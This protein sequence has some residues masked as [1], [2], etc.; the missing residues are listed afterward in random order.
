MKPSLDIPRSSSGHSPP[1]SVIVLNDHGFV[2]GGQAKIAIES[3]LH[4]KARGLDVCFIAGVG[5]IDERLPDSGIDCRVVGE[6][7]ILSDPNRMRAAGRG[8]WNVR[9]A[10]ELAGCVARRD[11]DSTVIH[12][13][14]WA[15]ALSPSIGPVMTASRA[16]HVY[17][18]HEYFLACPTGGF[19]HH[20]AGEI[21]TRR[22]L[23]F[24]CL[25]TG[26]DSRSNVHKMWRVARQAILRTAGN[27]PRGLREIIYLAP[28][29]QS[30]M[31]PFISPLAR[32][33]YLPNPVGPLPAE[34]IPA[35]RNDT[36]LFIGRLSPEKGAEVAARAAR[37]AGVR[38]AFAGDGECSEAVAQANPDALMLGWLGEDALRHW[39]LQARC[40]VFPSLW[41]ECYPLVVADAL[42][43]GLPV[44]VSTSTVAASSI[45]D[46]VSGLH[47]AAG[48]VEGWADAMTRLRSDELV[49]TLGEGAF[50]AGTALLSED[51]YTSRLIGIYEECLARKQVASREGMLA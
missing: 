31:A 10:R 41:Y 1:T 44:V 51:E 35:E 38:I 40:L 17:T 33:H 2:S 3:A 7:D 30:I 14:G 39:M 15:K 20:K 16:A 43:I 24:D 5:P 49:R 23:G 21:C 6:H 4:L 22:P 46:G 13:H 50:R 19:Y 27:M 37:L 8:T 48:D 34:R 9:A 26:C 18:M 28:E 11:P 42:R 12:A 47:R 36:I 29:Q 25:T 45:E 32:W